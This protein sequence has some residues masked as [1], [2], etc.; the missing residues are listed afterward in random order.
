MELYINNIR[1][2]GTTLYPHFLNFEIY[3]ENIFITIIKIL[4]CIFLKAYKTGK[5]KTLSK[6]I[7]SLVLSEIPD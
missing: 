2:S 4:N 5:Q 1:Y 6:K 7:A 3:Q